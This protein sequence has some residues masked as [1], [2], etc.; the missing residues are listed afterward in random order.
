MQLDEFAKHI[1]M[2]ARDVLKLAERGKLP[3]QKIA[4]KWRFNRARI[5][6][7]LQQE[8]IALDY[9]ENRLRSI[10]R[11]MSEAGVRDLNQHFV[12]RRISVDGVNL[13]LPA[14]TKSSVLLELVTLASNT[15]LLWDEPGLLRA[16]QEREGLCSTALPKGLAIP[17]P[18]QPMPYVS[19]EPFICF[20]RL[21]K[22]IG[23][24]SPYGELTRMF[25]LVC[26]HDDRD[27]L[28]VLARL[29]RM[30]DDPFIAKLLEIETREQALAALIEREEIVA[31][32]HNPDGTPKK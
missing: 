28:H 15:G 22:G 10:E 32:Q 1:G 5:T 7:W 14:K 18:R 25:F 19:S 24:G 8:M 3:G 13:A 17:H 9:D 2:D 4:G 27:H 21:G 30:L 12:T 26:C 31:A 29:I 16:L 11:A 20:A 23:F 6:E